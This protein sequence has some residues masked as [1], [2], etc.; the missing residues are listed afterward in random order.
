MIFFID[1]DSTF[2]KEETFDELF[3]LFG[4]EVY[5]EV[6]EKTHANMNGNGI[7]LEDSLRLRMEML[8]SQKTKITKSMVITFAQE[9]YHFSEG[10]EYFLKKII[11]TYGTLKEKVYIVSGGFLECILP[12]FE[13]LPLPDEQKNILR[14]QVVANQFLWNEKNELIGIDWENGRMWQKGAKRKYIESLLHS[15]QLSFENVV[16]IGDGSNDIDMIQSSEEGVFVAFI[17]NVR[18]ENTVIAAKGN[19]CSSFAELV[20]YTKNN[21]YTKPTK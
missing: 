5:H 2:M 19:V 17:G 8:L 4:E 21:K 20:S 18:R 3:R 12:K 14:S 11:E 7:S 15:N 6:L 10:V 16:A 1:N 9:N 13:T